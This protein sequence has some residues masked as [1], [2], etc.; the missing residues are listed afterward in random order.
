MTP[1]PYKKPPDR[2]NKRSG[3]KE[4]SVSSLNIS[5]SKI[6]IIRIFPE[7]YQLVHLYYRRITEKIVSFCKLRLSFAKN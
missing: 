6:E 5:N 7:L 1:N 3:A 4:Y 2:Q